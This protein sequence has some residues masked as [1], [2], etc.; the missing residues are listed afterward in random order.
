MS[1]AAGAVESAIAFE[2]G[3][4]NVVLFII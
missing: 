1:Q 4:E 3:F 2:R